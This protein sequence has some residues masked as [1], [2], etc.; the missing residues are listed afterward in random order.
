MRKTFSEPAILFNVRG[1]NQA[2]TCEELY[3][4]LEVEDEKHEFHFS[5]EKNSQEYFKKEF[6]VSRR[7]SRSPDIDVIQMHQ[8]KDWI[9]N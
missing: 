4:E 3:R 6:C 8:S 5:A 1:K 7:A 9:I 2:E